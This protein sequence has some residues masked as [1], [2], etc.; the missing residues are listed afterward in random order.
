MDV[1]DDKNLNDNPKEGK[2]SSWG[3]KYEETK[4]NIS[5]KYEEVSD[6]ISDSIE[7]TKEN[8]N[9]SV[10]TGV[11]KTKSFFKK[12]FFGIFFLVLLALAGYM[13]YCNMTYSEGTRTGQLIKISKKG[14]VFKTF[15]GQLNTG[16]LQGAADGTMS[17]IWSFSLKEKGMYEKLESLEGSKVMLRYREINKAMPWQGDTNYFVYEVE[18][19]N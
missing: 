11:K 9:E 3:D 4:E 6:K 13:F 19:R 16:G 12:L 5:E 15:E 17:T 2:E 18:E 10:K 8:L 1:N 7:E 14:Y